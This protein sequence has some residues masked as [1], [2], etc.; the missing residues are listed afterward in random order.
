MSKGAG[1]VAVLRKWVQEEFLSGVWYEKNAAGQTKRLCAGVSL[2]VPDD[3]DEA[4]RYKDLDLYKK[5]ALPGLWT[6]L[7]PAR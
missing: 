4:Q 1:E 5:S 6:K 3:A 2:F 7:H